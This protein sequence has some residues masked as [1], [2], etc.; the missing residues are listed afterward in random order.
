MKD[1][2]KVILVGRLGVDPIQRQTK[3][4]YPVAHFTVATSR[5]I[6]KDPNLHAEQPIEGSP[7]IPVS[8]EETQWH[9]IV[10]WGKQAEACSQYLR[11]GHSVYIEGMIRSHSYDGKDGNRKTSFE[12]HSEN[13]SFLGWPRGEAADGSVLAS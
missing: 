6:S 13:V 10:V 2:N 8:V 9:K 1:I 5:K 12:I 3:T 7:V 4:G 11:K